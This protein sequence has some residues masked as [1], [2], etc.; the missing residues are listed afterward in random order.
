[1]IPQDFILDWGARRAPWKSK[2]QV[3]QDLVI[4]RALVEIFSDTALADRLAFR[5]GTA[6][7]K[8]FVRPAPRYSEDIDLVQIHA[9][10]IG[11]TFDAIR[12]RLD[13]WLGKPKWQLKQG[14]TN[15]I[16]RFRADDDF[17]LRLKIEINSREH[18]SVFGYR[19]ETFVCDS[20]WFTGE[21][22]VTTFAIEELLGTKLRALYQRKEGT[23]PVR[24][25][26]RLAGRGSRLPASARSIRALHV[27]CRRTCVA[28]GIR[29]QLGGEVVVASVSGRRRA[30]RGRRGSGVGRS[31]R[32]GTR[33]RRVCAFPSRR[34][35]EGAR[36]VLGDEEVRCDGTQGGSR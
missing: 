7:Y 35:V 19:A 24:R 17:R 1:M 22:R 5:G 3:E 29:S 18:F 20:P 36:D 10:A 30:D 12:A 26:L 13:P 34:S 21:A 31:T 11:P 8:L 32:W 23:R 6:L 9:E 14:R 15:L 4:S 33:T 2:H 25:R 27:F 16:Y 28:S